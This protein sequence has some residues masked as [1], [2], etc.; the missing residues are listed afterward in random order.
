MSL[1][2]PSCGAPGAA[3]RV[4]FSGLIEHFQMAPVAAASNSLFSDLANNDTSGS[5]PPNSRTRSRVSLSS[6]HWERVWQG[7]CWVGGG[8]ANGHSLR[9]SGV[10]MRAFRYGSGDHDTALQST[11]RFS[12][13]RYG[14][15][16]YD[17]VLQST[18][19]V[20]SA[21]YGSAEYVTSFQELWYTSQ[22][23]ITLHSRSQIRPSVPKVSMYFSGISI[24]ES[25][26]RYPCPNGSAAHVRGLGRVPWRSRLRSASGV[27]RS[28]S[29]GSS[30]GPRSSPRSGWQVCNCSVGTN[31]GT[32][33]IHPAAL[34]RSTNHNGQGWG[35]EEWGGGGGVVRDT[36]DATPFQSKLDR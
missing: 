13:I 31:H 14:S 18:I 11:I 3:Y 9:I 30:P 32:V 20:C 35:G 15:P 10:S 34:Q 5:R 8:A 19:R 23:S 16:E 29:S 1:L 27:P 22:A 26:V 6:A 12:R 17:T 7:V 25:R 4:T 36:V 2:G 33:L 28:R 24:R 21:Q